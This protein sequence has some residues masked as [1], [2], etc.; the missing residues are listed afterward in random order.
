MNKEKLLVEL[1][2]RKTVLDRLDWREAAIDHV[3]EVILADKT[4]RISA[5]QPQVNNY[6]I[7]LINSDGKVVD[8]FSDV[9]LSCEVAWFHRMEDLYR[10]VRR[11]VMGSEQVIN[12]VL[13]ELDGDDEISL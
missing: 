1:L 11:R 7:E 5:D 10:V 6:L 13:L 3:F 8:A 12:E 9:D 2:H 4:V